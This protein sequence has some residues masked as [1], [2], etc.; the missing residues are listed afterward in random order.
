MHRCDIKN[1]TE[2]LW[3]ADVVVYVKGS[4]KQRV[5]ETEKSK[6]GRSVLVGL[7]TQGGGMAIIATYAPCSENDK[8]RNSWSEEVSEMVQAC[9]SADDMVIVVGDMNACTRRE[10]RMSTV[11]IE[12][13]LRRKDKHLRQMIED[14]E[15]VDA[16]DINGSLDHTYY[17][18][19]GSSRIDMQLTLGKHGQRLKEFYV[20][21]GVADHKATVSRWKT[22]G[23]ATVGTTRS[24]QGMGE[25]DIN[26]AR[27][28]LEGKLEY[29]TFGWKIENGIPRIE[30]KE[31][32]FNEAQE[33][34]REIT[35]RIEEACEEIWRR[36]EKKT[37]TS[38]S[39]WVALATQQLVTIELAAEGWLRKSRRAPLENKHQAAVRVTTSS[40]AFRR[41]ANKTKDN[42]DVVD[43]SKDPAMCYRWALSTAAHIRSQVARAAERRTLDW[44]LQEKARRRRLW[45]ANRDQFF[46]DWK[47]KKRSSSWITRLEKKDGAMTNGKQELLMEASKV[48]DSSLL[49]GSQRQVSDCVAEWS[50]KET[51]VRLRQKNDESILKPVTM[52]ELNEA[53]SAK[54]K[55]TCPGHQNI[56]SKILQILPEHSKTQIAGCMSIFIRTGNIPQEWKKGRIFPIT[57][58]RDKPLEDPSNW[59]PITLLCSLYK[60]YSSVVRKRINEILIENECIGE[61]QWAFQKSKDASEFIIV[62]EEKLRLL[63]QSG[64]GVLTTDFKSAYDSIHKSWISA[65]LYMAGFG[66]RVVELVNN[67]MSN[68]KMTVITGFGLSPPFSHTRGTVQGD[69]LSVT[70]FIIAMEPL[71]RK[72]NGGVPRSLAQLRICAYADDATITVEDKQQEMTNILQQVGSFGDWSGTILRIDKCKEIVARGDNPNITESPLR[73]MVPKRQHCRIMGIEWRDSGGFTSAPALKAKIKKGLELILRNAPTVAAATMLL[74]ITIIPQISYLAWGTP[75]HTAVTSKVDQHMAAIVRRVGNL[76]AGFPSALIFGARRE[77]G[78]GLL[79][80][81]TAAMKHM[82]CNWNREVSKMHVLPLQAIANQLS[83]LQKEHGLGCKPLMVEWG[84]IDENKKTV[85]ARVQEAMAHFKLWASLPSSLQK[86]I[87]GRQEHRNN[88][89][90]CNDKY[91]KSDNSMLGTHFVA[92]NLV[93]WHDFR[94]LNR[95]LTPSEIVSRC[96]KSVTL[97]EATTIINAITHHHKHDKENIS[98]NRIPLP[99]AYKNGTIV[100][101]SIANERTFWMGKIVRAGKQGRIWNDWLQQTGKWD[102]TKSQALN[103]MA[104]SAQI[105]WQLEGTDAASPGLQNRLAGIQENQVETN[106]QGYG[107]CSETDDDSKSPRR[108]QEESES[109]RE[110]PLARMEEDDED[111]DV[112]AYLLEWLAELDS[113][114]LNCGFTVVNGVRWCVEAKDL[115]VIDDWHWKN[116]DKEGSTAEAI[117]LE[118]NLS[119]IANAAAAWKRGAPHP[120]L[121]ASPEIL[122]TC[123][124]ARAHIRHAP[125]EQQ[126]DDWSQ[127]NSETEEICMEEEEWTDDEEQEETNHSESFMPLLASESE[128]NL[129]IQQLSIGK[130]VSN[131]DWKKGVMDTKFDKCDVANEARE[132]NKGNLWPSNKE[133]EER[134]AARANGS[135]VVFT[136]GSKGPEGAGAGVFWTRKRWSDNLCLGL[137]RN[138]DNVTAELWGIAMAIFVTDK[139]EKVVIVSDCKPAIHWVSEIIKAPKLPQDLM[140]G[141]RPLTRAI[142]H[143]TW[144]VLKARNR[145]IDL[146][147]VKAHCGRFANEASDLLAKAGQKETQIPIPWCH[148]QSILWVEADSFLPISSNVDTWLNDKVAEEAAKEVREFLSKATGRYRCEI[149]W[150]LIPARPPDATSRTLSRLWADVLPLKANL[151]KWGKTD[152]AL[153]PLCEEEEE[154]RDH[155]LL[156]CPCYEKEKALTSEIVE[157]KTAEDRSK[158]IKKFWETESS[159]LPPEDRLW[160][161]MGVP[162]TQTLNLFTHK[163]LKIKIMM[164]IMNALCN[165]MWVAR[166][167]KQKTTNDVLRRQLLLA[168][169]EKEFLPAFID[170]EGL[171]IILEEAEEEFVTRID[172]EW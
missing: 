53:I 148:W 71:L 4:W 37:K 24:C 147:W 84:V 23:E 66:S 106:D 73:A 82:I 118:L 17:H 115:F 19:Y 40:S 29:T 150:E 16:A 26:H 153:C 163:T 34:I 56:P 99:K 164:I 166:C 77:G 42:P 3:E 61:H 55:N 96:K 109:R 145:K 124:K 97:E 156:R 39:A 142:I 155:F 7:E 169:E 107:H 100:I 91:T 149:P 75:M 60:W 85:M 141:K 160:A 111:Y 44:H 162:S 52:E 154:T 63:K 87:E 172:A 158:M 117:K 12:A 126:T 123:Y 93:Q 140:K 9:R 64:G 121:F 167:I 22:E 138:T 159:A 70:L 65:A 165:R 95:W 33:A 78:L 35:C 114:N 46:K 135:L 48:F 110:D 112:P 15:L 88:F 10:D 131:N 21:S 79:R 58:D 94:T 14:L 89:V 102:M 25:E 171:Q 32:S 69:V 143:W 139:I 113:D 146:V 125:R 74:N 28:V 103:K 45:I 90:C 76:S 170:E 122:S 54:S 105:Q 59:R 13:P 130:P 151:Y 2:N 161:I 20:T 5:M 80:S 62:L 128:V 47:N 116:L 8:E 119:T 57:K 27:K 41:F 136:D 157:N 152:T 51:P 144:S 49:P 127:T 83:T 92:A 120:T 81:R 133:W 104:T 43:D 132:D 36:K 129:R 72:I 68:W 98:A 50:Y 31:V 137:P 101:H 108:S 67:G 30:G 6:S 134:M 168:A 86:D 18:S 38:T 11:E 1:T